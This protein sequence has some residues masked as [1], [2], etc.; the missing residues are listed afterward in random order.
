MKKYINIIGRI[1]SVVSI[2][3]VFY[4]LLKNGPD[5]DSF[6]NPG[7]LIIA[8][9]IGV[10]LSCITVYILARN[11]SNTVSF[12]ADK[13][14]IK[15]KAVHVYARANISKYIP[16]SVFQYIERNIFMNESGL[17]QLDIAVASLT[18]IFGLLISGI[19]LSSLISLDGLK[20][21]L[22]TYDSTKIIIVLSALAVIGIS[23]L[24]V[25]YLKVKKFRS[26]ISRMADKRFILLFI[27]NLFG[28]MIV[29]LI[30]GAIM[31][32]LYRVLIGFNISLNSMR[33]IL[34]AY[35]LSWLAGYIF[36]GVPGGIGVREFVISIMFSDSI[37]GGI[38]LL[39]A[40]LQRVSCILG[41]TLAYII[42]SI[43]SSK[44]IKP[45]Q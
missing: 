7:K 19:I 6:Q 31:L 41:D 5:F 35:I 32:P 40:V 25:L 20:N 11:W 12:L 17:D 30:L 2:I 39:C 26:I 10:I 42:S 24:I 14:D 29:L 15:T 38:I 18:E 36:I 28:Y 34:G 1:L 22:N 9:L 13:K 4:K 44:P 45:N 27:K 3:F 33:Q 8:G 21:I 16:G 37:L 23:V 43:K